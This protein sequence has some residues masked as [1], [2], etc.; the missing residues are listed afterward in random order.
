MRR[1]TGTPIPLGQT[2]PSPR[3]AG[4]NQRLDDLEAAVAALNFGKANASTVGGL[5]TAMKAVQ[6]DLDALR[7]P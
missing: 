4:S 6:A 3:I 7:R 1:I 2:A 5:S